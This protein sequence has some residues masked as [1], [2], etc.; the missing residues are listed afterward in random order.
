M[1]S[2]QRAYVRGLANKT[3]PIVSVGKAGVTPELTESLN[4]ALEARELVKIS[5]L[6]NCMEDIRDIADILHDRTHS[7]IVQVI[8]SK[9]VFFRQSKKKPV[10]ELPK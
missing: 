2:K 9:A 3:E 6:Q 4:I 5:V 7:E 1:T 10:I 8:G